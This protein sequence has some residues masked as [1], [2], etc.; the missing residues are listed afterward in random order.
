MLELNGPA[1]LLFVR[2]NMIEQNVLFEEKNAIGYCKQH[3]HTQ[4]LMNSSRFFFLFFML[5]QK[6]SF[7]VWLSQGPYNE[8]NYR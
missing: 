7:A 2:S 3:A 4:H 8:Q 5:K 1:T 6:D